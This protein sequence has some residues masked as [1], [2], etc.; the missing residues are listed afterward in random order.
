ME[1]NE[2]IFMNKGQFKKG[3]VVSE[4]IR[5]KIRIA[6]L[7]KKY[8]AEHNKKISENHSGE[9]NHF[10]GKH[11]TEEAKRKIS[12]SKKGKYI[13]I[14]SYMWN[15]HLSEETKQKLREA[16]LGKHQSETTIQKRI[17]SRKGYHHSDLTK[18]KLSENNAR[19]WKGKTFSEE[20][21]QKMRE[22]STGKHHTEKTKQ[23]LH[24]IGLNRLHTKETRIKM[25]EITKNHWKNEEIAKKMIKGLWH[26]SGMPPPT[27][28]YIP[29]EETRKKMSK[30]IKERWKD[31]ESA[32]K[33]IAGLRIRPNKCELML[34]SI[35]Q[36]HFP[37]EWK[38]VGDGNTII[39]GLCPD[40]INVNGKKKIIEL[41][42]KHWH[43]GE[44]LSYHRTEE[45]RRSTFKKIGFDMLVIWDY[46][47]KNERKVI[48]KIRCF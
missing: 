10:Y 21:K 2:W 20:T 43:K 11:H 19:F 39:N 18:K 48:E 8:S 5:E 27:I 37:N 42:G 4:E 23:K 6:N 29:T 33:M 41:F 30:N 13:G 22:T 24:K 17:L 36:N 7:G 16:N 32:K 35:L 9:K 28:G 34:D 46:E 26:Q 25:S 44:G 38:Y 47:L 45:G 31:E 1:K 40:F 14:N 12:E 3:H 15:K